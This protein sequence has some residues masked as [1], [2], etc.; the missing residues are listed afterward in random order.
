MYFYLF[1]IEYCNLFFLVGFFGRSG[2][3]IKL[4]YFMVLFVIKLVDCCMCIV[5]LFMD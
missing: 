1:G 2:R 5:S 3:F 4:F